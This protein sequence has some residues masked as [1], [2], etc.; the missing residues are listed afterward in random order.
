MTS[1]PAA[2]P[3]VALADIAPVSWEHPADRAALQALRALPGVDQ[4][5]RKILGI[6]GGERGIRLI[7]QGN[8]IRV[9]PTQFP[10]LWAMH[11]ENCTTFGWEKVPE[12]Y[13]T[14][15]PIF[16]AGAYGIDDPFIVIHSSAFELLDTDEQRVL[17][18]HELGHVMSG[19]A[20]Y[21]TIA[22]I[23]LLIS[24][25]ALPFP[26]ELVVLPVRLAFLEWS[27]KSEL[28]ADRAGLLGSQDLAATMRLFMK[29]AGGANTSNVRPGDLNLEPF[30]VQASEYAEQHDGFDIVYKVLNTLALTHPMNVVR[31]G[32]VQKWVRS[33]AYE[34]IVG[35]EYV[36]R[37]TPEADERPLRDDMKDAA[38][39]YKEE[40]DVFADQLKTAAKRAAE[41]ARD[42][43]NEARQRNVG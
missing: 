24:L 36:R 12:L 31:A 16:N 42:A 18:A 1:L 8:A 17:L 35:G 32:E 33:G 26:V 22:A 2:R 14:Q 27:R 34:R 7:F 4:V 37:G 13:V 43:F 3:R 23:M 9:G 6:L 25:G 29:M 19:H 38:Q 5:I 41:R 30:M 39:H 10:Q 20:L 11:L 15:T 40:F 28:S 21:S